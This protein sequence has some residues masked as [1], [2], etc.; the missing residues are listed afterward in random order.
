MKKQFIPVFAA[1]FA[2]LGTTG[3]VS[4]QRTMMPGA[5]VSSNKPVEQGKYTVL[6]NGNT[7]TG[8]YS[9]DLLKGNNDVS[10]SAMKKAVDQALA[11][12]PG[13]DALVGITIDN[14]TTQKI[15]VPFMIPTEFS[16]TTFV[17]GTP[18]KTQD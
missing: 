17:T 5:I 4:T 14:M 8:Q 15:L 12:C 1:V 6:N 13:A 2:I 7:V 16:F 10:G 18:V 11:Q 3:C 9:F